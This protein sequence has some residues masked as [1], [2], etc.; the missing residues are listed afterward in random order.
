MK[1]TFCEFNADDER[2]FELGPFGIV[3]QQR[4]RISR[5]PRAKFMR[6][7]YSC[8]QAY[9]SFPFLW[10]ASRMTKFAIEKYVSK[11]RTRELGRVLL[12]ETFSHNPEDAPTPNVRFAF[13]ASRQVLA[14]G[15]IV[16]LCARLRDET[17]NLWSVRKICASSNMSRLLLACEETRSKCAEYSVQ[18]RTCRS[19]SVANISSL[20]NTW[21][22]KKSF[23]LERNGETRLN[24]SN[25]RGF[26][27]EMSFLRVLIQ[28]N[29]AS[30]FLKLRQSL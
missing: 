11:H 12:K 20:R 22:E 2:R 29:L 13:Q 28:S 27:W 19:D 25:L 6:H 3:Q 1:I 26:T 14:S 30:Y 16:L 8:P 24:C 15:R 7:G 9:E 17:Q 10:R 5:M 21:H 18:V 4:V 23:L